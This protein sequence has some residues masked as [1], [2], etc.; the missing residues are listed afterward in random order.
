MP[1]RSNSTFHAPY[2]SLDLLS[3]FLIHSLGIFFSHARQMHSLSRFPRIYTRCIR[4]ELPRV[5]NAFNPMLVQSPCALYGG[6]T[7]AGEGHASTL[8]W[9]LSFPRDGRVQGLDRHSCNSRVLRF[10]FPWMYRHAHLNH[11]LVHSTSTP[12]A[13]L[14]DHSPRPFLAFTSAFS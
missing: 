11:Y 10:P 13:F 5:P 9:T 2:R 14:H 6:L 1:L 3:Q 12:R 4:R 7:R 8:S